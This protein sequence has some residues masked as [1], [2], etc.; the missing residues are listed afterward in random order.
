MVKY[1]AQP[2]SQRSSDI[3]GANGIIISPVS[4]ACQ[5][6]SLTRLSS[7]NLDASTFNSR[8]QRAFQ[9]LF[10]GAAVTE[11]GRRGLDFCPRCNQRPPA[12]LRREHTTL[13]GD[14]LS[15]TRYPVELDRE[16]VTR[17]S[18]FIYLPVGS[19]SSSSS[20]FFFPFLS[21]PY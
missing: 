2:G 9:S 18:L 11:P 3:V 19:S 12:H 5:D 17:S 8:R 16:D 7:I 21:Q 15:F 20:P 13:R 10:S 6:S 1:P 4:P 14:A